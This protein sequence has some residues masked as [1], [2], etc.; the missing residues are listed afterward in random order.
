MKVDLAAKLQ[1]AMRGGIT[2]KTGVAGVAGVSATCANSL[3]LQQLRPLRV[4]TDKVANDA[5]RGVACGV[6]SPPEPDD[7][8]IEERKGMA[9]D[10][11]PEPYLDAWARLQCQKPMRV[12]DAEWRQA[13]GDAGRFLDQW[14]SLAVE[15]GWSP[16][17]LFDAPRDDSP[18]GLVWFIQGECIEA[19][20]HET[21]AD[22]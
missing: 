18:G 16:G 7:A 3:K 5:I 12:S 20:G 19:I 6:A 22:R 11:V 2:A 13:I 9:S 4:K 10:S 15:F 17:D 8:G 14:G 1:S 21:G